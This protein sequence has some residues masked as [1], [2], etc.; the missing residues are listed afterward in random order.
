M[1][2]G[3]LS[4]NLDKRC[5][6]DTRVVWCLAYPNVG[7]SIMILGCYVLGS[8]R[9]LIVGTYQPEETYQPTNIVNCFYPLA[10]RPSTRLAT[11]WD[12]FLGPT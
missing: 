2:R 8:Q 5:L 1:V 6:E 7:T 4:H 12:I 11:V 3:Y 10:I 9:N